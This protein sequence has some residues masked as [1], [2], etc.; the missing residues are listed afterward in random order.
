MAMFKSYAK[1]LEGKG[2]DYIIVESEKKT[3][4]LERTRQLEKDMS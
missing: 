3:T 1:L 2:F 4:C